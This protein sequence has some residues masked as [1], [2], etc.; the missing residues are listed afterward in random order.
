MAL[1]YNST[2]PKIITYQGNDVKKVVY[3]GITIWQKSKD[4][5]LNSAYS[6]STLNLYASATATS[7]TS[8]TSAGTAN[9]FLVL[10]TTATNG[11]VP[12]LY[13]A[14]D[15]SPWILYWVTA[16]YATSNMTHNDT[17]ST[18]DKLVVTSGG[19]SVYWKIYSDVNCTTVLTTFHPTQPFFII[20]DG[21]F[22][23]SSGATVYKVQGNDINDGVA[24][25]YTGYISTGST[26]ISIVDLSSY[27]IMELV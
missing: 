21:P 17:V 12:I 26:Y 10:N 19:T 1:L 15:S 11:R 27:D 4:F 23:N 2:P 16:S 7:Y 9:P 20:K 25:D 24:T 3:K 22:T 5:I 13:A 8:T 18:E 14:N 6:F